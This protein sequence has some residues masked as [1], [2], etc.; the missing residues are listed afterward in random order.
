MISNNFNPFSIYK[1]GSLKEPESSSWLCNSLFCKSSVRTVSPSEALFLKENEAAWTARVCD[2][3]KVYF[4]R[5][6]KEGSFGDVAKRD[7]NGKVYC[8]QRY[9]HGLAHGLRQGALARDIV[10]VLFQLKT[11]KIQPE[12]NAISEIASWVQEK[13]SRDPDFLNKLEL[14]S[15]FQRSGR[16]SEESSLSAPEAYE[17]YELQDSINFKKSAAKFPIFENER[18]ISVFAESILWTNKGT[19]DENVEKDLKYL[20][21]I[22]HA[23]HTFDLRRM[24]SFDGERIQKDGINQL[25]GNKMNLSDPLVSKITKALWNRSGRYLDKTGDRDLASQ[26]YLQDKF[27]I[28][29]SEPTKMTDAILKV[30]KEPIQL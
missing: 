29:S 23:A 11:E 13:I 1:Y 30:K 28:Q 22:L 26:R 19:I 16:E 3:V 6:Y 8:V 24:L 27:F 7:L 10:E 4:L 18:E 15:S 9:N 5:P 14:A 17:R 2:E 12:N 25:F 20:K 21:R